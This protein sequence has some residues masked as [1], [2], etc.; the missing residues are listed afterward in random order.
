[1][2]ETEKSVTT[3]HKTS[4][5]P[6]D[7]PTADQDILRKARQRFELASSQDN[8]D[9][10]R[11]L[12][13]LHF[14]KGG[15]DQWPSDV[16]TQRNAA[17]RPHLTINKLPG[18]VKQV[19]NDQRQNRPSIEVHPVDN[20]SD[21]AIAQIYEGM[22]RNIES[23]SQADIAYDTAFEGA[24]RCGRGFF[25]IINQYVD[26]NSFDQELK[27]KRIINQFSVYWDP[28]ANEFDLS[29]AQWMFVTDRISRDEFKSQFPGKTPIDFE[30]TTG[31][32][33]YWADD[34]TVRIAEYWRKIPQKKTIYLYEDGVVSEE[35]ELNGNSPIQLRET[36]HEKIEWMI[37]DGSQILE[38][39]HEWIG[40][41]IPIISVWGE[42]LYIE[43]E[44]ILSGIIR[45][46]KDPQRLYNYWRTQGAE[47]T[48][49]APS[50]PWLVT[51]K[52]IDGWTQIWDIVD[53]TP[54]P[55]LPYNPDP[56]APGA[57]PERV[58]PIQAQQGIIEEWQIANDEMKS[59]TGIYDASLGN[60]S[61]E[62]SGVAIIARQRESDVSN[63]AYI[64][65]LTRALNYTGRIL[66]DLI[67]KIY[68]KETIVRTM[69][70]DGKKNMVVINKRV[71]I[72]PQT[73]TIVTN[74]QEEA[75]DAIMNDITVGK[76]DVTVKT[77][78]SYTTQRIKAAETMEKFM[79]AVPAIFEI[80]GDIMVSNMD[81]PGADKLSKRIK[82]MLPPAIQAAEN[83]DAEGNGQEVGAPP[84]EPPQPP[85]DPE[86]MLNLEKGKIQ[87][88]GEQT[89]TDIAKELLDQA[90][91]ETRK[92]LLEFEDAAKEAANPTPEPT[93]VK[94][95]S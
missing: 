13:D 27:I 93:P 84:P 54:K 65:N 24:A 41:H 52:M 26:E 34:K 16:I 81:W 46:A 8:A 63:Y 85:P 73:N 9:R 88:Q 89:K 68:N 50:I 32:M 45:Q 40:K 5:S 12:D 51:A 44:R 91:I 79:K 37:I 49:H 76:Y 92:K 83:Q 69:D 11:A 72:N 2:F 53:T 87:L 43:G 10:L 14:L 95:K 3:E 17:N 47:I 56:A 94:E 39:S 60:R 15:D 59:T 29:D 30:T 19:M 7:K 18:F 80:G 20:N 62:T 78:P 33:Q 64:D 22:I 86:M 82:L 67:P 38:D 6:V 21:P 25:R 74:P 4:D 48:S 57:K 36:V 28:N 70:I 71:R 58:Q 75:V 90:K 42:E 23:C 77:G 61:N 35:S 66:I 55:Y 31:D 1:M